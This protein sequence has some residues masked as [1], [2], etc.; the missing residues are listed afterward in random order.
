M[1]DTLI[2]FLEGFEPTN[3]VQTLLRDI[4]LLQAK[5]D[6][7]D[8]Y[9]VFFQGSKDKQTEYLKLAKEKYS[10]LAETVNDG[11][12]KGFDSHIQRI[13]DEREKFIAEHEMNSITGQKV[14]NLNSQLD[15]V[16]SFK[17]AKEKYGTLKPLDELMKDENALMEIFS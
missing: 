16:Q 17:Q 15:A 4:V 9:D 7:P 14:N 13:K 8:E 11:D 1:S 10:L 6:N 2:S 5:F 3:E 12:L